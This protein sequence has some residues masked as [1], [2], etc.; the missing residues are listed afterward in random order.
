MGEDFARLQGIK[1]ING[2]QQLCPVSVL[3]EACLMGIE[4]CLISWVASEMKSPSMT[5]LTKSKTV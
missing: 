4:Y 2:D 3:V 5:A 1:L